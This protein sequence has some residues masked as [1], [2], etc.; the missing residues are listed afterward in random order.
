[1][2]LVLIG[3]MGTGKSTIALC[4]SKEL[5]M[6]VVEMDKQIVQKEQMEIAE[7]FATRGETYFRDLETALLQELQKEEH[8]I[9]SCG[10]GTPLRECNVVEMKKIGPV[11]LLEAHPKTIWE[12][13][14]ENKE[15][16]LLNENMNIEYI[17]NL[18]SERKEKYLAA[19]DYVI[20]T[21]EKTEDEICQEILKII[22]EEEINV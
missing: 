13:V 16:P 1:M 15:R 8:V 19:A 18:M 6:P 5:G 12:R 21:D 10:G 7:I 9:I 2:G 20:K 14:K 22:R 3:F 17:E 4:L 11:F